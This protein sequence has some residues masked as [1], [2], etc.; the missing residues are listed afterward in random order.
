[1]KNYE[2]TY[3]TR[4]DMPEENAKAL[5]D[6]LSE[7]VTA[8]GGVVAEIAKSYRKRLAYPIRKQDSAYVNTI[9]FSA[10]PENMPDF[11]K[12][13][14]KMEEILRGLI[15]IREPE[16]IKKGS[17]RQRPIIMEK[18]AAATITAAAEEKPAETKKAIESEPES[19]TIAKEKPIADAVK[20]EEKEPVKPKRKTKIKAEL[21]DIEEKLDEI[22]K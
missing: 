5:Q 6:K 9:L 10:P 1:M 3:L 2:Y 13:T 15:I 11:K 18:E 7:L 14:G 8:K 4:S 16:K 17:R 21:R 12:K 22:L 19:K 20:K